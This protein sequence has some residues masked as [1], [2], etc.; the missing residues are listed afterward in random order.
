[1]VPHSFVKADG[2]EYH[3]PGQNGEKD[4]IPLHEFEA[5]L[6]GLPPNARR[7]LGWGLLRINGY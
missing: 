6:L 2:R 4:G 3:E 1:M 7:T 5:R